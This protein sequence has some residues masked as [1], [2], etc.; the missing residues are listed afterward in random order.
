MD[1][2]RLSSPRP[3]AVFL[4]N[5][6]RG[7]KELLVL[8]LCVWEEDADHQRSCCFAQNEGRGG[9]IRINTNQMERTVKEKLWL[10][11]I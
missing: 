7:C 8:V 1:L 3:A 10:T 4:R 6:L 5:Y 2:I 9:G 11:E